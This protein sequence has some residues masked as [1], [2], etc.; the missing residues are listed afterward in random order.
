ME[1]EEI[2][3]TI[4][5]DNDEIIAVPVVDWQQLYIKGN[6]IGLTY[7]NEVEIPVNNV[8]VSDLKKK[9]Q[10]LEEKPH[11]SVDEVKQMID[12]IPAVD[13]TPVVEQIN[14]LVSTVSN[15]SDAVTNT[16]KAVTEL[17]KKPHL[18][19]DEVKAL[20]PNDHVTQDE[21]FEEIDTTNSTL[22]KLRNDFDKFQQKTPTEDTI[23]K[24]LDDAIATIV[25]GEEVRY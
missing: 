19:A 7:G 12:N 11:L 13:L 2:K 22:N 6:V 1:C 25:N 18:S 8:D 14:N 10:E 20:I 23:K 3:V 15:I 4:Q 5:E 17:Q 9:V 21:F 24:L 16:N